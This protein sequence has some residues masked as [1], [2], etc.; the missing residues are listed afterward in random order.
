MKIRKQLNKYLWKEIQDE[1]ADKNGVAVVVVDENL[2]VVHKSNNN[3]ICW[4]LYSSEKFA[5][6]CDK[7]CGK[8]FAMASEAGK[9]VE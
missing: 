4:I 2:S 9:A 1:L 7:F 6:E 5:P 3:S 8:A